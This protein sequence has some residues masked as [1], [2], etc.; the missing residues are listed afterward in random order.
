MIEEYYK[1]GLGHWPDSLNDDGT[2][3]E[4][5]EEPWENWRLTLHGFEAGDVLEDKKEIDKVLLSLGYKLIKI[6]KDV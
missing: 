1:L 3:S 2:P 4:D 6:E 5:D